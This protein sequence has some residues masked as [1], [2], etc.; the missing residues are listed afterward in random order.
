[1]NL[2]VIGLFFDVFLLVLLGATIVFAA[3]LSLSLKTF[4]NNREILNT[5]I[6]NLNQNVIDAEAVIHKLQNNV[7]ETGEDL[8]RHIDQ[9]TSLSD[10]LSLM[11][12]AGDNLAN[13]LEKAVERTSSAPQT[14][15]PA[16][17]RTEPQKKAAPSSGGIFAIRDPDLER[18]E[19]PTQESVDMTP[20]PLDEI[21]E[22]D[23]EAERE[24]YEALRK[25]KT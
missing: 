14:S 10:E 25:G 11:T 23:T 9:A 18:A 13:R 24:L 4:K 7:S 21:D 20:D 19:S 2:A 12:Q 1:M 5:M 3:K 22:F 8:Q 17:E 16:A 15:S 6:Q